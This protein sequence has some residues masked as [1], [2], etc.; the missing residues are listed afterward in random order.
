[1]LMNCLFRFAVDRDFREMYGS[2]VS[3]KAISNADVTPA[4]DAILQSGSWT[5]NWPNS[6]SWSLDRWVSTQAQ[7]LSSA[8]TATGSE[9]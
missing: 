5:A 7:S 3:F 9:T 6:N 8:Y 1:M 4:E 2:A